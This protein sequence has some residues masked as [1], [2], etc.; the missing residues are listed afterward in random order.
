MSDPSRSRAGSRDVRIRLIAAPL[1]L[2]FLGA[3]LW[4]HDHSGNPIGSDLLIV[5]FGA[6]AG[7][8]MA[9][10]LTQSGRPVPS[11][12][13]GVACGALCAVGILAPGNAAEDAAARFDWRVWLVVAAMAFLLIRHLLDTRSEAIEAIAHALIPVLYIGLPLSLAREVMFDPGAARRLAWVVLVAKA[14]DMGGWVFGKLFGKHKMV[15]SVSPGKS[16]EGTAGGVAASVAVAVWGPALL[17]LSLETSWS[18]VERIGF[19][20]LLAAVSILAGV[21]QSGWKRRAGVKDSS[22][23]IPEMGGMLDMAD[24][25]LFAA[26]AAV[27]WYRFVAG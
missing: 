27:L 6:G 20:T 22:T 5:L 15:P 10:L 26:P 3:V 17:G 16:W 2:L 12:F 23:L 8:E 19:G 21:T 24:S 1:V 13:A 9:R 11:L 18:L 25:I 7:V 14:S 4:W